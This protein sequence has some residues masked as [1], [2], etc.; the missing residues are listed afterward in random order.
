MA[1][2]S[3][4]SSLRVLKQFPVPRLCVAF[5]RLSARL[6]DFIFTSCCARSSNVNVD[7][8]SS[9]VRTDARVASCLCCL[10]LNESRL[11]HHAR[12]HGTLARL[13]SAARKD[14]VD[15][16]NAINTATVVGR[17]VSGDGVDVVDSEHDDDVAQRANDAD[18]IAAA[19]GALERHCGARPVAR[20]SVCATLVDQLAADVGGASR[21]GRLTFVALQHRQPPISPDAVPSGPQLAPIVNGDQI[22]HYRIAFSQADLDHDGWLRFAS[23]SRLTQCTRTPMFSARGAAATRRERSL[24][25]AVSP[26]PCSVASGKWPTSTPTVRFRF[27][28]SSSCAYLLVGGDRSCDRQT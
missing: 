12:S 14:T 13:S 20:R 4:L 22:A 1:P 8:P 15:A 10:S 23:T 21:C 24:F 27:A 28:S 26:T 7:V 16:T 19:V 9:L 11:L 3:A 5:L 6:L 18:A 2:S 25:A 17:F